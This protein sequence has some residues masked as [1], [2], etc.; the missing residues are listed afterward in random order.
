MNRAE[1]RRQKKIDKQA[2]QRT[3]S[4]THQNLPNLFAQAIKYQQSGRIKEAEAIYQRILSIKP[5]IAEVHCNL[6][7]NVL[8]LYRV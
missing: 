5:D 8:R 2:S 6:D 4:P 7:Y 1:K 3:L